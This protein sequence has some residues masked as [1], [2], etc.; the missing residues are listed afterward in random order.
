MHL[1]TGLKKTVSVVSFRK[2]V[3]PC[4]SIVDNPCIVQ[5]GKNT[6]SGVGWVQE[7]D[8]RVGE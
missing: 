1:C 5:T 4:P 8:D 3:E 2:V 7:K 6:Y